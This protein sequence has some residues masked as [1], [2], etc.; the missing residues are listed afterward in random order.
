MRSGLRDSS[1]R[2]HDREQSVTGGWAT[3]TGYGYDG[4]VG[5]VCFMENIVFRALT[6]RSSFSGQSSVSMVRSKAL[7][8]PEL[9]TTRFQVLTSPIPGT[10]R[11]KT[12]GRVCSMPSSLIWS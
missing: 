1:D 11:A 12:N 7:D 3:Q 10:I 5:S 9:L 2:D 4:S 8:F 6:I